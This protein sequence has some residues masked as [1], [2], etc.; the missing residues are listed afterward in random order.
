MTAAREGESE[1]QD[2][3][4]CQRCL[5]HLH[6]RLLRRHA[7][8]RLRGPAA[9]QEP[10]ETAEAVDVRTDA[11]S[12]LE[13]KSDFHTY[14]SPSLGFTKGQSISAIRSSFHMRR[15]K[16]PCQGSSA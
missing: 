15:P 16:E 3:S 4:A 10:A 14:H 13:T 11:R 12:F 7:V 2:H 5:L 8:R 9:N 1:G 6:P